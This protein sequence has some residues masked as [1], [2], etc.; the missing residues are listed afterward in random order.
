MVK[1]GLPDLS[2]SRSRNTLT[3]GL[4]VPDEPDHTIYV[5]LDA[6]TNYLT[7]L[8]FPHAEDPPIVGTHVI[9]KDILKCVLKGSGRRSEVA[10]GV[11]DAILLHMSRH[12][13][14][15]FHRNRFHA[16]YWPA[17]L[18]AAGLPPPK[19]ILV[20]GHWTVNKAKVSRLT[21]PRGSGLG[22]IVPSQS[23]NRTLV[24]AF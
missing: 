19:R 24:S 3:W 4:P 11:V 23:H 9:G 14:I 22:A 13:C 2:V 18:M 16:I 10:P 6:L 8:G 21:G 15:F 17:F 12:L 1:Q 20:H 7:V 5:W